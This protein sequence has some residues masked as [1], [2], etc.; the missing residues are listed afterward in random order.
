[1]AK[2]RGGRTKPFAPIASSIKKQKAEKDLKSCKKK[3][4]A[5][6]KPESD[7]ETK[8]MVEINKYQDSSPDES[9]NVESSEGK[10]DS[11]ESSKD[12]SRDEED[13]LSF[14]ICARDISGEL[15]DLATWL[16][17]VGSF[18]AKISVRSRMTIYLDFRKILVEQNLYNEFKACIFDLKEFA[19]I[20]GLNCSTYP[21]KSKLNKVL[22]K[23]ENFHFKVTRNKNITGAKLMRIIK[24]NKLNKEQKL[25]CSL[26]WFVH[27]MLLAH[28]RSKIVDS[29]HIKMA[30]D[31]DFFNSY[32]WGKESFDLALTYL[33]NRINL[34]KQGKMYNEKKNACYA[35]YGFPWAVLVWIYKA[36]SYLGK[37][38][39][40]SLDT[41]LPI[42]RLLIWYTSKSDNI[43]V[44]P[45][46][47]PTV[48]EM[49]QNYMATF[50]PYKDE[51]KD[52]IIDVLK[53][54][55]KGVT[56]ITLGVEST[57]DKYLE[58]LSERVLSLEQLMVKVVAYV[59]E[60]RLR[61]IEKNKKTQQKKAI[62]K[63]LAIVDEDFA[64]I[65][66]YLIDEVNDMAVVVLDKVTD[67]HANEVAVDFDAMT[68]DLV[69]EVGVVVV[70]EVVGDIIDEMTVDEVA[71]AVDPV[72]VN[73]VDEVAIDEVVFDLVT[74]NVVNEVVSVVDLVKDNVIDEMTGIVDPVA[75][76]V[77]DEVASGRCS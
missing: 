31:L 60:E 48:R 54:Q 49:E 30:D 46:L 56:V 16:D 73:I 45:Y 7:S 67:D 3:K 69:D 18:P 55:L 37:Y 2:T 27:S 14:S 62:D 9:V 76:D 39:G 42:S 10:R 35:L 66:E 24:S 63:D 53:A 28:D 29:N 33:K 19:L 70:D 6:E 34:K 65:D 59:R 11:E 20:T 38:A 61:R 51:V 22:R 13:P 32:P 25:K 58:N 50:K 77:I 75:A 8:T 43:F 1:M 36:F 44:H 71:G 12:T 64:A 74:V 4:I 41:P 26:V 72:A 5:V 40:K 52:A 47:T 15:Y 21:R 23:G 68:V 17:E 57:N